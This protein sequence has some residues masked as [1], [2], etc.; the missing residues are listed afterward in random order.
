MCRRGAEATRLPSAVDH[1]TRH[2]DTDRL[3]REWER[4]RT[5]VL[6]T[7]YNESLAAAIELSLASPMFQDLDPDARALLGAVAFFPQCVDENNLDWLFPTIPNG[8]NLF[9]K[10]CILSLTYRSD[11]F[12]TMLAQLDMSPILCLLCTS[13]AAGGRGSGQFA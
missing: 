13:E 8:I 5:D 11:G 2:W 6:Q 9:D 7:Q 12:V 1:V 10:F 3:T 4:H